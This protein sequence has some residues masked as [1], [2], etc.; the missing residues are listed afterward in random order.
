MQSY[1]GKKED[2]ELPVAQHDSENIAEIR[3]WIPRCMGVD[4]P[5][6]RVRT[7]DERVKQIAVAAA[8][9]AAV[10]CGAVGLLLFWRSVPGVFGEWLGMIVGVMSTPFFLEA[11]FVILGVLIVMV[12]NTIR[13]HREG[14]DF[15]SLEHLEARDK[16]PQTPAAKD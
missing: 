6:M 11:S 2:C 13:R 8:I 9:L 5:A 16:P 14:D 15:V 4:F 7:G 3:V 1:S 10:G 12:L